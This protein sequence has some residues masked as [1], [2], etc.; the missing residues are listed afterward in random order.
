MVIL[1]IVFLIKY[2]LDILCFFGPIERPPFKGNRPEKDK[3][4]VKDCMDTLVHAVEDAEDG[5]FNTCLLSAQSD[6]FCSLQSNASFSNSEKALKMLN[7]LTNDLVKEFLKL[8]GKQAY[9]GREMYG[10]R[11]RLV[12]Q[13]E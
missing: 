13:Y 11:Y 6:I 8:R 4:K 2:I 12:Y 7:S 3:H 9:V 10:R 1:K 5:E